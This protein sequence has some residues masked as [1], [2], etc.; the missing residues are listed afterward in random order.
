M[1]RNLFSIVSLNVNGLNQTK[2]RREIFRYIRGK[3]PHVV[4]LQETYSNKPVEKLWSN[5]WGSKI[6]FS[7]G[8]TNSKGVACMF[9][10]AS[11]VSVD[12][13]WNDFEGRLL[14]ILCRVFEKKLLIINI[15][16][17]N[18]DRSDFF[19]KVFEFVDQHRHECDEYI[20][21]G[22]FNTTLDLQLDKKS[23]SNFDNHEEKR[24]VLNL[25]MEQYEMLD[26]WRIL[27]PGI[28]QFT[29]YRSA[30]HLTM[31]RLDYFLISNGLHPALYDSRIS[32]RFLTDHGLIALQL[33]LNENPKGPGYW[34][35]NSRHLEDPDFVDKINT[36]IDEY[37]Q[38]LTQ[39][40]V[41]HTPDIVWEGLK[42]KIISHAVEF[43]I[44]KAKSRKN[45]INVLQLR[46]E[47][48]DKK[49]VEGGPHLDK[50]KQDIRKTEEFMLEEHEKDM[51]GAIFRSKCTFYDQGGKPSKYFFSLEK[52]RA[53]AKTITKI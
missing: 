39:G 48:L 49:L 2:K 16:A 9:S 10:K 32:P 28:F 46:L 42:A 43:L 36:V 3:S 29:W 23:D 33:D 19:H 26:A 40:G 11:P 27:N 1:V 41:S 38:D 37:L 7:H 18:E 52:S 13:Y 4:L 21:A 34:K 50:I 45:L 8:N 31:S 35:L 25:Y 6:Y 24:R 5:E 44:H 15:Y 51:M 53:R 17:L 14:A 47:K 12:S 30:P 20:I 22:D